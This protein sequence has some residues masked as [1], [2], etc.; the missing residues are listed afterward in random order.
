MVYF[1]RY[2]DD[3]EVCFLI[4]FKVDSDKR[5]NGRQLGRIF[6]A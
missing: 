3:E 4:T 6:V 2:V 5:K 1:G